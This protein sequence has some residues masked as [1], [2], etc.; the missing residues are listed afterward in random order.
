VYA[1]NPS[2]TDA[3]FDPNREIV[4]RVRLN[5]AEYSA[6]AMLAEA[7]GMARPALLREYLHQNVVNAL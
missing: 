1:S 6:L 5:P 4:L 7:K 3:L 2:T